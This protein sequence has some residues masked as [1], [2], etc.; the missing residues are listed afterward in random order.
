MDEAD[1]AGPLIYCFTLGL[2]LLLVRSVLLT[3]KR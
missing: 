1:L 3:P 2:G